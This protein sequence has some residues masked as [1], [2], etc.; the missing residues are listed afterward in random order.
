MKH[1]VLV[2]LVLDGKQASTCW[3]QAVSFMDPRGIGGESTQLKSVGVLLCKTLSELLCSIKAS[4]IQQD[5]EAFLLMYS[6]WEEADLT[7]QKQ[8][9][10]ILY[11]FFY[12]KLTTKW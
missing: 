3:C 7:L 10:D 12:L 11:W 2:Q 8:G 1:E 4:F 9:G 5:F 6:S